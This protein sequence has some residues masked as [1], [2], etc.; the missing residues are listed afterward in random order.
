ML[1]SSAGKSDAGAIAGYEILQ[2]MKALIVDDNRTNQRILEGMLRRWGMETT[3]TGSA[4]QAIE[5]LKQ[6]SYQ[7]ILTDMYM[8]GMDGFEMVERIR[9]RPELC[10]ATIMMLTSAGRRGDAKRCSALGISAY[11]L[12]PVR[13]SELCEAIMRVL[14]RQGKT[15]ESPLITRFSLHGA[16]NTSETLRV[17]VAE[18]NPVN[19][20]LAMRLL[21]KRGHEVS[22]AG[23]G[24][25]AVEA[26]QGGSFDLVLMDVQMPEMDGLDATATIRK[27][28]ASGGKHQYIVALT[29]HAMKG[30]QEK[31]LAAGMDD[32]LTK[33]IRA[34][35]L[36]ATI[37]KFLALRSKTAGLVPV[38]E[39]AR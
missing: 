4:E 29:A 21:E 24:R 10:T 19:Q 32:Y 14:A 3:V 34:Q 11:L 38:V 20:R 16:R 33:P 12:K 7:L 26:L 39:Q 37:E 18:D 13:Q 31:C 6:T 2:G 27:N 8:P 17:L 28:E 1:R 30:D 22:V 5:K 36:E 15:A 9:H 35:E 25:E 23:N